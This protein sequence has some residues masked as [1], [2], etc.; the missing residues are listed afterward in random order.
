VTLK[1]GG[2]SRSQQV[3]FDASGMVDGHRL[4]VPRV[5]DDQRVTRSW[6]D[7]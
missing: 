4:N 6:F 5:A 1:E 3:D 7:G 2:F